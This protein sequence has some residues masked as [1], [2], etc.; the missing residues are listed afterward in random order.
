[1]SQRPNS[2]F[3]IS[4][5]A[6]PEA[7]SISQRF[8]A[9]FLFEYRTVRYSIPV[10]LTL[11]LCYTRKGKST[12]CC[13]TR[14]DCLTRHYLTVSCTAK[15]KS[16][17]LSVIISRSRYIEQSPP[18]KRVLTTSHRLDSRPAPVSSWEGMTVCWVHPA[19]REGLQKASSATRERVT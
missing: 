18:S 7:A 2:R 11:W 13:P 15:T 16:H 3:F 9:L 8:F 17:H 10:L 1:M 5:H 6:N 12:L 4:A 19:R 14:R